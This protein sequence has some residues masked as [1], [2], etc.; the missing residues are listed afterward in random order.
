LTIASAITPTS[1]TLATSV[2]QAHDKKPKQ[3][4]SNLSTGSQLVPWWGKNILRGGGG[5]HV[6]GAKIY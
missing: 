2:E 1:F 3:A 6:W 5:T 4:D